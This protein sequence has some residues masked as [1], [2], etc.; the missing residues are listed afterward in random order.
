MV[1]G[2]FKFTKT[3]E[4]VK[5]ENGVAIAGITAHAV[6]ELGDIV[7]VET[8]ESGAALSASKQFGTIE[9]TKAASEL[10]A[11]VSGVLLE[12]NQEVI[13]HPQLINESPFEKGWLVKIKMS[14]EKEIEE[15]LD[16]KE[17]EALVH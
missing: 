11:P 3:H 2:N 1:E 5:V 17:Y 7:F 6:K 8:K 12:V 10:Y 16:L 15:L 9:S 13:S 14:D 4:W